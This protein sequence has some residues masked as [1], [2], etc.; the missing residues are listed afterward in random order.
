VIL[1]TKGRN[2]PL[3]EQM[4]RWLTP[5]LLFVICVPLL[6]MSFAPHRKDKLELKEAGLWL[7]D[8]GY[9]HSIILGQHEFARLAFYADGNYIPLPKGSYE[10]II[11]FAREEEVNLLVISKNTIDNLSPHFLDIVSPK[12]LHQINMPEVKTDN[13]AIMVFQVNLQER[14]K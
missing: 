6:A 2:F 5:L 9:A 11:R 3:K 8:N 7:R 10:Y 1:W 4:L 12:D 13:Y 14:N